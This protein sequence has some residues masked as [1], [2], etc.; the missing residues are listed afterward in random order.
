MSPG[1]DDSISPSSTPVSTL[2]AAAVL[3]V[4]LLVVLPGGPAIAAPAAVSSAELALVPPNIHAAPSLLQ[5]MGRMARL[6]PTFRAQCERIAQT[7]GLVVRMRYAGLRDDRPFNAR[8]TVRRHQ[9][10]AVIAEVDLYVP[11]DPV[12]IVA[13]EFEHLI[14]QIQGAD[15]RALSRTRGSGVIEV[16]RNEFETLRAVEAGRRVL[17]EYGS[18]ESAAI[19]NDT[20][21]NQD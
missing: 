12:E 6:S 1:S 9:Y 15:L 14:E 5:L 10:G 4:L 8:T 11:L 18:G 7:S 2:V 16:R 20:G 21:V 3:L 19:E 17:A 13:H